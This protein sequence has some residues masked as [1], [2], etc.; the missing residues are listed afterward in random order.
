MRKYL[1]TI[2]FII[3]VVL[4][5]QEEKRESYFDLNYFRGNITLHNNTILHLIQGHPE[6]FIFS[7]NKKTFGDQA[8][9][10]R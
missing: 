1:S 10:Q 4:F 3:S 6:G 7:W 5:A 2:F 8:W 9:E